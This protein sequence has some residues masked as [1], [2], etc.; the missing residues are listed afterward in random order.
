MLGD[1]AERVRR[2]NVLQAGRHHSQRQTSLPDQAASQVAGLISQA[3]DYVPNP[4]P[5]FRQY[6]VERGLWDN[7]RD[8]RLVAEIER[9]AQ[10]AEEFAGSSPEP[11]MDELTRDVYQ[12]FKAV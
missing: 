6:L 5:R 10:V 8:R 3:L 12:P 7:E 2:P 9:D 4:L 1:T 11:E